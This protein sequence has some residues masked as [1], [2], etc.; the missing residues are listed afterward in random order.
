MTNKTNSLV[1]S[2]KM[3]NMEAPTI[4]LMP[5]SFTLLLTVIRVKPKIPIHAM[6]TVKKE[7]YPTM[8]F[9]LFYHTGMRNVFVGT[10][11]AIG[12]F[13]LSY[14]GYESSDDIAGDLGCVFTLRIKGTSFRPKVFRQGPYTVRVG[15]GDNFRL[16]KYIKPL[17]PDAQAILKV[18]FIGVQ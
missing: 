2:F 10:L 8:A 7:E 1:T 17:P 11:C 18:D 15:D 6:R 16:K 3:L 4:F 9:H 14:K 13:L 12:F 5:I